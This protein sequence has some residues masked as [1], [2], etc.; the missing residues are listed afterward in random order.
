MMP[1]DLSLP[2]IDAPFLA[3][4]G[5]IALAGLARGLSGFGSGMIVAPVAGAIYGPKAALTLLVLIDILPSLPVTI[6]AFRI[7]RWN[8]VIPILVGMVAG[9]PLGI[10][11]LVNGDEV[12]LRWLICL[13]ILGCVALLWM[14]WT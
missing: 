12:F 13:T 5:V 3:L 2:P 6:P 9:V 10:W 4:L 1:F 14:R 8:E 7:A 11:V